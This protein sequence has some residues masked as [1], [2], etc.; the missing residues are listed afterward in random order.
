[1]A[2]NDLVKIRLLAFSEKS[3]LTGMKSLKKGAEVMVTVEEAQAAKD[4]KRWEII[5]APKAAASKD[6]AGK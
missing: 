3:Q 5:P 2:K 6:D 1:M 4:S